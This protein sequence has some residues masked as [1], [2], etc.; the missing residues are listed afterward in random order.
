MKRILFALVILL[1]VAAMCGTAIII[2]KKTVEEFS[3]MADDIKEAFESEDYETCLVISESFVD[4][5]KTKSRFFPLFMRHSDITRIEETIAALP[6]LLKAGDRHYFA[7][8][9]AKCRYML[10]NLSDYES[11]TLDNLF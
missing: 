5:F 3:I 7:C 10:S 4:E 1:I 11:P 2:Q 9:L 6:A 8:E